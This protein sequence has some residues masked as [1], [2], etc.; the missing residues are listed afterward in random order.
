MT[1]RLLLPGGGEHG[2]D[3]YHDNDAAYADDNDDGY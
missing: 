3:H 2:E 1:I